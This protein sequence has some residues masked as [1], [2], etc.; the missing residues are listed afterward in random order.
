[1]AVGDSGTE[2]V[3]PQ[4]KNLFSSLVGFEAIVVFDLHRLGGI[5]LSI[6]SSF[7]KNID[8]YELG[9]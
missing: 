6:L 8:I 2:V 3:I 5:G 4:S 1:V 9:V 7:C